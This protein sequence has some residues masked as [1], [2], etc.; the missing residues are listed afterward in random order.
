MP[1]KCKEKHDSD[2]AQPELQ[3]MPKPNAKKTKSAGGDGP[4]AKKRQKKS[5]QPPVSKSVV[6]MMVQA[7]GG[8]PTAVA[9]AQQCGNDSGLQVVNVVP[10]D[11]DVVG[12]MHDGE[13]GVRATDALEGGNAAQRCGNMVE[14][15]TL[16]DTNV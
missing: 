6:A 8:N 11:G 1:R 14:Q 15:V 2:V 9:C 13:H 16:H 12:E 5:D 7:A 4:P 3:P 10:V